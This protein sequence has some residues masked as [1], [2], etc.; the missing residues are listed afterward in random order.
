MNWAARLE[1]RAVDQ[2]TN[3]GID[4][5]RTRIEVETPDGN[6]LTIEYHNLGM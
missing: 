3:L 4:G 6:R 2:D 1:F 5:A